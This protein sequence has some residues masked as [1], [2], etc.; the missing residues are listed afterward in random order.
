MAAA[1][2]EAAPEPFAREAK[3][4]T[5]LR[6]LNKEVKVVLEGVSQ[7][8]CASPRQVVSASRQ[9][10]FLGSNSTAGEHC[11]VHCHPC[12]GFQEAKRCP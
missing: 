1:Q 7:V 3:Y 11:G 6:V 5:E 12:V 9:R 10:A 4:F 8:G 2:P